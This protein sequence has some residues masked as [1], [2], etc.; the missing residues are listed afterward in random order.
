MKTSHDTFAIGDLSEHCGI[1][2]HLSRQ[3][4]ALRSRPT[5]MAMKQGNHLQCGL[6]DAK[7]IIE[8]TIP[9]RLLG[10]RSAIVA[11]AVGEDSLNQ[12]TTIAPGLQAGKVVVVLMA[13]LCLIPPPDR[14]TDLAPQHRPGSVEVVTG[15]VA[16]LT[17][18]RHGNTEHTD[19]FT[20]RGH[21]SNLAVIERHTG[22][23]KVLD[24]ASE[25]VR[26]QQVIGVKELDELAARSTKAAIARRGGALMRLPEVLDVEMRITVTPRGILGPRGGIVR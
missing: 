12:R 14:R 3:V 22:S 24:L 25:F 11:A 19:R 26:Q 21:I 13:R 23:R 9:L 8:R 17:R 6:L 10:N 4:S 16:A 15:D 5:T 20:S 7:S 2:K 1:K 18:R